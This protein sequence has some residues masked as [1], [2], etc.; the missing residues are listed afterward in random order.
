VTERPSVVV[1]QRD[2]Q[3]ASPNAR[4]TRETIDCDNPRCAAID[5]VDQWVASRGVD[6]KVA[7][8]NASI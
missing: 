8:I 6:S 2:A 7:T 5:R 1:I 4:H 3:Q